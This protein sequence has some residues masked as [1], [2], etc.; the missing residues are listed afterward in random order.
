VT[1]A[2]ERPQGSIT[3]SGTWAHAAATP[4]ND[5][6]GAAQGLDLVVVTGAASSP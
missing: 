6:K 2:A 3:V 4:P 5:P 1:K